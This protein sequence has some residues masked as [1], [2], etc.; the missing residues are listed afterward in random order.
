[1]KLLFATTNPSKLNNFKPELETH[2]IEVLSL[3]DID[4]KIDVEETG[5]N[6]VEN[7]ILKAEAY[8]EATKIPS[9]G[10]DDNLYIDEF[11][12][13]DQPGTHVRRINGKE[14]TDDEMIEHY[15]SLVKKH[16]TK[17]TCMWTYGMALATK[18]GTFTYSWN[19]DKF[20][21]VDTP[22][23]NRNAR[24]PLNSISI[25]PQLNKY[26]SDLTHEDKLLLN[27]NSTNNKAIDFII[28]TIKDN[29]L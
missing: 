20:F 27:Q 22:S 2:G 15:T 21:L 16:G 24:Y 25:I 29:N 18:K 7:A 17:L 10:M 6:A 11:P 12:E 1:M 4:I 3:N 14:L 28:N 8:Y 26:I 5:K 9:L 19:K 13:Q 23:P